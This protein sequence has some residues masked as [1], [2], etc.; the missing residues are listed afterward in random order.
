MGVGMGVEVREGS[1]P[2]EGGMEDGKTCVEVAEGEG[3]RGV[4]GAGRAAGVE[5]GIRLAAG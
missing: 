3:G 1:G 4:V 2:E 5:A